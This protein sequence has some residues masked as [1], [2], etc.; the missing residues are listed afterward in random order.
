MIFFVYY[1]F[2]IFGT[3]LFSFL[4]LV[5]CD[6]LLWLFH[7]MCENFQVC[8]YICMVYICSQLFS[9]IFVNYLVQYQ[10]VPMLLIFS[11]CV[12]NMCLLLISRDLCINLWGVVHFSFFFRRRNSLNICLCRFFRPVSPLTLPATRTIEDLLFILFSKLFISL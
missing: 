9:L 12:W 11:L 5:V 2:C 8:V 3:I 4:S 7:G 6:H 10:F 1:H